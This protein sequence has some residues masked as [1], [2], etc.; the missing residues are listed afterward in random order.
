VSELIREAVTVY[1]SGRPRPAPAVAVKPPKPQV[2]E[3]P[4]VRREAPR[5]VTVATPPPKA[6]TSACRLCSA[7]PDYT[8]NPRRMLHCQCGHGVGYHR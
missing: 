6:R 8:P 1:L 3:P 7:C 2:T 5:L 4:P